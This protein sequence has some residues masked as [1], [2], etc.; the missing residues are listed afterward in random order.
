MGKAGRLTGPSLHEKPVHFRP[1]CR[2]HGVRAFCALGSRTR[3]RGGGPGG[4]LGHL[5][6]AL[7][8]AVQPVLLPVGQ[9]RGRC[10][11]LRPAGQASAAAAACGNRRRGRAARRRGRGPWPAGYP[12]RA[13][14][15]QGGYRAPAAGCGPWRSQ[16]AGQSSPQAGRRPAYPL[17]ARAASVRPPSHHRLHPLHPS[18]HPAR[19]PG[20][21]A[22]APDN[23]GLG[24]PDLT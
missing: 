11:G 6:L 14:P 12:W 20:Q 7:A 23:A 22:P 24:C 17:R 18:A 19:R 10:Q 3:S 1:G 4:D 2:P 5:P 16:T 8:H 21:G 9:G 13:R 15:P